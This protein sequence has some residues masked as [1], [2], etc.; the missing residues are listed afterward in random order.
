MKRGLF[1][2]VACFAALIACSRAAAE[3]K[4]GILALRGPE[5]VQENWGALGSYLGAKLDENVVLTPLEFV[6]VMPFCHDNPS[7]L[8]LVNPIL[9]I[10]VKMRYGATPLVTLEPRDV[11]TKFG[12]VI[13][14]KSVSPIRSIQDMRDK[15]LMVTKFSSAGGWIYQ[16][17]EIVKQGIVPEKDCK[18]IT[19]GITHDGVVYAVRDGKADVGTIRTGILEKLVKEGKINLKDYRVLNPMRH[20]GFDLLCSTALYPEW[21]VAMLTQTPAALA[22]KVKQALLSAPQGAPVLTA[23][24]LQ[25]FAEP[26]DYGPVEE[27]MRFLKIDPFRRK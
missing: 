24:Q 8:L 7:A 22:D 4:I 21:P 25:A 1:V 20:E 13:F 16:K 10:K 2:G 11:G 14:V 15:R 26:L 9:F 27:M 18:T 23:A 3:V 12:G 6:Q 17:Y 5:K 19:E